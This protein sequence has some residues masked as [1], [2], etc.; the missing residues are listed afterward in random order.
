[1]SYP[2]DGPR[3][4]S[5]ASVEPKKWC[6]CFCKKKETPIQRH[7]RELTQHEIDFTHIVREEKKK[8][9]EIGNLKDK[10]VTVKGIS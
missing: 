1:M 5:A 9:F 2:I 6:K 7:E 10:K 8:A 4:T 3:R